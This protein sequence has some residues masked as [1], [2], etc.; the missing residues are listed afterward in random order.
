MTRH[1]WT[2]V[3]VLLAAMCGSTASGAGPEAD[4]VERPRIGL[5]VTAL[6][7]DFPRSE[8]DAEFWLWATTP[9]TTSDWNP[10]ETVEIVD[11]SDLQVRYAATLDRVQRYGNGYPEG[12][13]VRWHTRKVSVTLPHHWNVRNYPF[14]RQQLAIRL[15]E[16]VQD[17]SG[18]V[19]VPDLEESRLSERL[20]IEGWTISNLRLVQEVAHYDTTFGDPE[21][22]AGTGSEYSRLT[23]TIELQRESVVSF[24]KLTAGVYVAFLIASLSF[25]FDPRETSLTNPRISMLV[26]S[27]FAVLVNMRVAESSFAATESITLIDRIHILTLLYLFLASVMTV[28]SRLVVESGN[29]D[30]ALRLDR[31]LGFWAFTI[32]YLGINLWMIVHAALVG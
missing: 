15:E 25:F 22:P 14:D 12:T 17:V 8:F 4:S 27:L 9:A 16:S 6:R 32:S 2:R 11:A 30:L 1:R 20:V 26:G 19:Y 23:A 10:L 28:I 7:F 3:P 24:W 31:R 13:R 29:R 21:L 18:V 5:Y